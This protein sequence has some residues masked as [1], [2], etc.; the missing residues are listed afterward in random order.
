LAAVHQYL[1]RAD[2][3]LITLIGPLGIGKTRLSIEA[4]RGAL[5][6]FPDGVFF[7]ALAR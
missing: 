5:P 6:H 2:I 7:I 4:A 3:R 1:L